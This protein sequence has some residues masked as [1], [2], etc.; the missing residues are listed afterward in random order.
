[1]DRP[2]NGMC[3]SRLRGAKWQKSL[4]SGAGNNN[5]VE[6]ARLPSGE[7]AMRNSRDPNGPALIYTEAEIEALIRGARAGEF[8]HLIRH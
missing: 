6:M 4:F 5:C 3:A 8:D 2:Y 7:V 1:M